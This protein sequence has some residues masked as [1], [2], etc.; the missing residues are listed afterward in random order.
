M[1]TVN[2]T[3]VESNITCATPFNKPLQESAKE[4]FARED[5]TAF[6]KDQEDYEVDFYR[7]EMSHKSHRAWSSD[8]RAIYGH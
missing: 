7:T 2:H 8:D 6:M 4:R 5:F 3:A 1:K